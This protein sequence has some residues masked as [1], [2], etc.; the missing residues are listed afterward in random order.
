ME[1]PEGPPDVADLPGA[2]K[3]TARAPRTVRPLVAL[4]LAGVVGLGA[5]VWLATFVHEEAG[6]DLAT[7]AE[8]DLAP[9]RRVFGAPGARILF[10]LESDPRRSAL[11]SS[12]LLMASYVLA[13]VVVA[14][15][16]LPDC[17][18]PGSDGCGLEGGVA[19]LLCDRIASHAWPVSARTG[20]A[21]THRTSRCV[22]LQRPAP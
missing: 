2:P 9:L 4:A 13:P 6:P 17:L 5:P 16:V 20:F 10:G 8:A 12:R 18:L 1:I 11:E 3:G 7:P 15:Y 21:Q 22:L 19:I 14:P